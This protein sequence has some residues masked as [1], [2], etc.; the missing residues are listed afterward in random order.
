MMS[1]E[2]GADMGMEADGALIERLSH[3]VGETGFSDEGGILS[4]AL[5]LGLVG[6][7]ELVS[8]SHRV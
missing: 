3:L 4:M 1:K 2:E 6:Y 7:P 5:S 8:A